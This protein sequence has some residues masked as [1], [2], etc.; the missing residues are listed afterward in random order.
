[1]SEFC[2][3][4]LTDLNEVATWIT[5][6]NQARN[7]AGA[8]VTYPLNREKLPEQIQWLVAFSFAL[9]SQER[10]IGFGQI[11]PKKKSRL[12]LARLILGPSHRGKGYGRTLAT[13]LLDE[14]LVRNPKLVS[15]N[16]FPG[17]TVAVAL[18]ARI[19]F[20][21]A[22]RGPDD[23]KSEAYYMVYKP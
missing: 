21:R 4:S 3:A 17:N 1:M 5:S 9:L 16:V 2:S 14:A 15:L 8:R 12:H 20:V 23:T 10:V 6:V 19:G 7:W 22:E 13:L 18:Y 11:V